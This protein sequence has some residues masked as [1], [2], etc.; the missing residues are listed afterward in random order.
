[1]EG[2]EEKGTAI[3]T[4]LKYAGL[5]KMISIKIGYKTEYLLAD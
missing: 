1:L 3:L 5:T 4:L 2:P